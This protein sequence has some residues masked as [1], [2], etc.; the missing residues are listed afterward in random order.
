MGARTTGLDEGA[1]AEATPSPSEDVKEGDGKAPPEQVER[2]IEDLRDELSHITAEL[3]RRRH[4][5]LEVPAQIRRAAP[6]LALTLAAT[7]AICVAFV[8]LRSTRRARR[9]SERRAGLALILDSLARRANV[10]DGRL[11]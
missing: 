9:E 7:A 5:A 3:D 2:E 4:N 1:A 8:L 6:S 10:S 11:G